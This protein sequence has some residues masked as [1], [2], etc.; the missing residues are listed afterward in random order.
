MKRSNESKVS[1]GIITKNRPHFL[2]K[3]IKSIQYDGNTLP[4]IVA[5]NSTKE[6]DK[7]KVKRICTNYQCTYISV[8]KTGYTYAR[9]AV[10]SNVKTRWIAFVDDDCIVFPDWARKVNIVANFVE[11]R[12]VALNGKV[13]PIN[14]T[15]VFSN[16]SIFLTEIWKKGLVK[17]ATSFYALDTKNCLLDVDFLFK[18]N[19]AF[20]QKRLQLFNGAGEDVDLGYQIYKK[21]GT[22]AS[23][24]YFCVKHKEPINVF[25]YYRQVLK[26]SVSSTYF[27][28]NHDSKKI[29]K[30]KG[31]KPALSELVLFLKNSEE[32]TIF[33][34]VFLLHCIL[35]VLLYKVLPQV[36]LFTFSLRE[37]LVIQKTKIT[38][39]S[40]VDL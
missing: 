36:L 4:I 15:N 39:I 17:N 40:R 24:S 2:L 12:V 35:S 34:F 32:S 13:V 28:L 9:N 33:K 8:E 38:S 22:I 19:L 20:N 3:C 11:N 6:I 16:L 25:E 7:A 23:T 21:G 10:L 27:L 26:R 14:S 18:N 29:I 1:V 5:D 30:K 37:F 31:Q